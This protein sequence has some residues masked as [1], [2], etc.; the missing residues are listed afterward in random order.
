MKVNIFGMLKYEKR[1]LSNEGHGLFVRDKYKY[2]GK[3]YHFE[4]VF[5]LPG[6]PQINSRIALGEDAEGYNIFL[7][8]IGVNYN[9]IDNNVVCIV[10]D[11]CGFRD[12][13]TFYEMIDILE[14]L[15][16]KEYKG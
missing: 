8:V 1:E 15:G 5:D 16:A 9:V 12:E 3:S 4:A 7:C 10:D 6:I 14:K 2:T 13:S 11:N